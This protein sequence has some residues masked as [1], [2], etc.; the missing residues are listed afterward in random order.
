MGIILFQ[1]KPLGIIH[2]TT[3]YIL[4][5]QLTV[6]VQQEMNFLININF[7]EPRIMKKII[8]LLILSLLFILIGIL[9]GENGPPA[10]KE[11]GLLKESYHGQFPEQKPEVVLGPMAGFPCVFTQIL[12]H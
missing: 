2:A 7:E 10:Q 8:I 5:L 3:C 1:L 9:Y 11:T 4:D 12:N 6:F